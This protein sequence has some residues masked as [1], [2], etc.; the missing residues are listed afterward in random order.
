MRSKD[1]LLVPPPCPKSRHDEARVCNC[2]QIIFD[3]QLRQ[4]LQVSVKLRV[5]DAVSGREIGV[6]KDGKHDP[7]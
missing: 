4:V 3:G 1:Q 2:S 6:L 5:L 7:S